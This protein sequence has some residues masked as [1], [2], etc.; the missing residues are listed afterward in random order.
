[1]RGN[2]PKVKNQRQMVKAV[3]QEA[4][5]AAEKSQKRSKANAAKTTVLRSN[6][7]GEISGHK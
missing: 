5:K 4:E 1:M 3:D 6:G 7:Q 2:R